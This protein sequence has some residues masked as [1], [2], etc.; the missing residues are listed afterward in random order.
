MGDFQRTFRARL[1]S[2]AVLISASPQTC[3]AQ[4]VITRPSSCQKRPVHKAHVIILEYQRR[5]RSNRH[6][7]TA[8][9]KETGVWTLKQSDYKP[10]VLVCL[11]RAECEVQQANPDLAR[12]SPVPGSA[13]PKLSTAQR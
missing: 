1:L 2:S 11:R 9:Q 13:D 7:H 12:L 6:G 4:A 5:P 8:Q 10:G 3:S